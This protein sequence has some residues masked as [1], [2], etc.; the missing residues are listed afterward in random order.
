LVPVAADTAGVLVL[1]EQALAL[2]A[3][4][5]HMVEKHPEETVHLKVL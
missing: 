4:E 5:I 2:E 1:V 3:I